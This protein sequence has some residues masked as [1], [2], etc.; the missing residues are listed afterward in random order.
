MLHPDIHTISYKHRYQIKKIFGEILG[1][2]G[3]SHFS[4]DL[5]RPDGEMIFFSSTPAHGFEICRF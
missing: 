3:V 2:D 1:T 5:V 4:L